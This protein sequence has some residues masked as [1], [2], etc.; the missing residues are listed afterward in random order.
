MSATI[1]KI[2]RRNGVAGQYALEATVTYPGEPAT[3][4]AFVGNAYGS[5]GVVVLVHP[6]LGEVIVT[7]PGR[8][9]DT[10][11]EDW[12]RRFYS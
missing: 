9:G 4:V 6:T 11:N 5:P 10:L 12:V 8:Y 7:E 1:G 2:T 3:V